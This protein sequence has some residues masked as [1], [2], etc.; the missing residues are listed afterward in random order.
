M[1]LT[2]FLYPEYLEDPEDTYHDESVFVSVMRIHKISD[3]ASKIHNENE[4]D[5]YS[6]HE[7]FAIVS[8]PLSK[9]T[10]IWLE[11]TSL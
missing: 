2:I 7:C 3:L 11:I 10:M 9:C 6:N 8:Y 5:E 4:K 1:L